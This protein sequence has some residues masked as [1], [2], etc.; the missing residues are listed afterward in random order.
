MNSSPQRC[1]VCCG[2]GL[3]SCGA[4]PP[5]THVE[6]VTEPLLLPG[7]LPSLALP[8]VCTPCP[9]HWAKLKSQS[10]LLDTVYQILIS[11]MR[12]VNCPH[13]TD[14]ETDQEQ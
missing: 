6:Q 10:L 14:E 7:H 9:S 3:G 8:L 2:G 13:F 5:S 4:V 1:V 12:E 11:P